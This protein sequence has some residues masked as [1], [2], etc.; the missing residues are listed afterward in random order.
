MQV[1]MKRGWHQPFSFISEIFG[2][3][4]KI[5]IQNSKIKWY[6]WRFFNRQKW[7]NNTKMSPELCRYLVLSVQLKYRRTIK[8][9]LTSY[10][11]YSHIWLNLPQDDQPQGRF[12]H[13]WLYSSYESRNLLKTFYIYPGATLAW[14]MFRKMF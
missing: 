10:L 1:R 8:R 3:K 9:I 2:Q 7:E 5:K 4:A 13:I 14:T 6:F 12:S 11:V